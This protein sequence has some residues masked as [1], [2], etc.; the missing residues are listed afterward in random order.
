MQ[1]SKKAVRHLRGIQHAQIL[2]VSGAANKPR[3]HR[4]EIK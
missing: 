1:Q 4:V 3:P 2:I